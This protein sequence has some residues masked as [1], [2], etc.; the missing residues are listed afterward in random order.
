V[1]LVV[2]LTG[3]EVDVII[4]ASGLE[5]AV[6]QVVS[7]TVATAMMR[8]DGVDPAHPVRSITVVTAGPD[9]WHAGLSVANTG[10]VPAGETVILRLRLRSVGH[11]AGRPAGIALRVYSGSPPWTTH[12]ARLIACDQQWQDLALPLI[13]RQDC[14]P[15]QLIV[16]LGCSGQTQTLEFGLLSLERQGRAAARLAP[17]PLAY[18]GREASA[19]WRAAAVESILKLRTQPLIVRVRGAQGQ[20]LA[21]ATVAVRQKRHAFVFGDTLGVGRLVGNGDINNHVVWQRP[22]WFNGLTVVLD[23]GPALWQEHP[24]EI[25]RTASALIDQG[26][27]L[28]LRGSLWPSGVQRYPPWLPQAAL[29][30]VVSTA[31][32]GLILSGM[33]V[34]REQVTS[35]ELGQ[36]AG[37]FTSISL[38]AAAQAVHTA[39]PNV[40]QLVGLELFDLDQVVAQTTSA[41]ATIGLQISYDAAAPPDLAV[42]RAAFSRLADLGRSCEVSALRIA[43]D[44][45]QAN[46]EVL[47]DVLMAAFAN[48]QV[49]GV[50]LDG[51]VLSR[52]VPVKGRRGDS[53][54]H[55]LT[56]AGQVWQELVAGRWWTVATT[57]TD[58][59]GEVTIPVFMG[60]HEIVVETTDMRSVLSSRVSKPTIVEVRP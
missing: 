24:A 52:A 1:L 9:P 26:L 23:E 22:S 3:E 54:A 17:V 6:F 16:A 47:R 35:I 58:S 45:E 37:R 33:A 21:N 50:T 10:H 11:D 59:T 28:R 40:R 5:T 4:P 46:A 39:G 60:D 13:V 25:R 14:E 38:K 15:G 57:V 41:N 31:D 29:L 49:Q 36:E 44:D 48:P 43:M 53:F 27:W 8:V 51:I 56:P 34:L 18:A 30:N 32:A 20:P 2:G 12:L 7:P 19:P 42:L 55:E